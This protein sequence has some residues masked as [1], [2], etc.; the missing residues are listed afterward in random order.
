MRT[1]TPSQA[2]QEC[3]VSAATVRRWADSGVLRCLRLPSGCRRF[4]PAAI[5]AFRMKLGSNAAAAS[6]AGGAPAVHLDALREVHDA[7]ISPGER[8]PGHSIA[9]VG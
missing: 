6:S 3:G 2:A 7:P 5:D 9:G 1:L 8:A 4:E